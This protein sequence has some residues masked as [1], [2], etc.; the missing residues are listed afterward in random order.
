M[1]EAHKGILAIIGACV[2]WGTSAIFYKFL[3]HVP[4]HEVL[5]HRAFWSLI[6]F[7]GILV[8]QGR[9]G[10]VRSALSTL[11][12]MGL[13]VLASLMVSVNWFLFIFATQIDRI[14]ETSLGY[15][16][17][18]LMAV[19][20]GWFAYGERLD[21]IQGFAVALATLAVVILTWGLGVAP[22]IS[23]ALAT[24][25]AFYGA[26]KKNLAVGP[27]V[28]VTCE[29]LVFLPV[30]ALILAYVYSQ[31][32]GA[33]A[34]NFRDTAL[35]MASGPITALPLILFSYAARRVAM[36]TVGLLQYINPTLQFFCAVV[37]FGETFTKWHAIAF[38][39]I[40]VALAIYSV[41]VFRQDRAARRV[42]MAASGVSTTVR[43]SNRDASANP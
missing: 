21:R 29:V 5:A 6:F 41:A 18:P 38:P 8:L 33:F 27:V 34:K 30:V 4:A 9:L 39:M 14:T 42:A 19:L 7:A 11:R 40:W 15:Y 26:I 10:E 24:T 31:G 22:W 3:V 37:L 17:F 13:I 20:I 32:P 36:S 12:G 2:I 43:K 1:S 23:L 16:I 35:L 28:S 25:F